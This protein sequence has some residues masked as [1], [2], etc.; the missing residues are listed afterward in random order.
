MP[1]WSGIVSD[2]MVVKI[3]RKV[4]NYIEIFLLISEASLRKK[5]TFFN[6]LPGSFSAL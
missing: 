6:N 2:E 4:P 5:L 3:T 1:S